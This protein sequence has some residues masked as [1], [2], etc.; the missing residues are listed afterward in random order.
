MLCVRLSQITRYCANLFN[1]PPL[2]LHQFELYRSFKKRR[3][4]FETERLVGLANGKLCKCFDKYDH[5]V[6]CVGLC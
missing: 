5:I 6:T 2:L 4:D 1:I 3:I